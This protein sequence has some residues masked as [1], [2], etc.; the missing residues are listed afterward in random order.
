M[1]HLSAQG[2]NISLDRGLNIQRKAFY[3]LVF[4]DID[5]QEWQGVKN[6]PMV[7]W[8]LADGLISALTCYEKGWENDIFKLHVYKRELTN[9][10]DVERSA[11][12]MG[13]FL[14]RISSTLTS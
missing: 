8:A 9:W 10:R 6:D 4:Y 14:G 2:K 3:N 7:Q 12:E 5:Q 1:Q 13:E 11:R